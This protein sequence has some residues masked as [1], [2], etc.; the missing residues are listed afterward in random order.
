MKRI[1]TFFVLLSMAG[2]ALFA[3]PMLGQN[4]QYPFPGYP[5]EFSPLRT[6]RP[7]PQDPPKPTAKFLRADKEGIANQYIITLSDNAVPQAGSPDDV[8]RNVSN[9]A[10]AL[11]AANGERSFLFTQTA[12]GRRVSLRAYPNPQ[13]SP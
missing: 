2:L 5:L 6:S 9:L 8:R 10:N 13:P 11:V 4:Q 12:A 3:A 1:T 7:R